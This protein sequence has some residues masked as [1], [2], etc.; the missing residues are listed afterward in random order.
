MKKASK[1]SIEKILKKQVDLLNPTQQ[2]KLKG[3][4]DYI[5]IQDIVDGHNPG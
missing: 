5:G 1:N 2:N 3:G 4:E